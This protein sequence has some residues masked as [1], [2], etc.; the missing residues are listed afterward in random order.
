[1]SYSRMLSR[2]R[3]GLRR[4]K[5]SVLAEE[6]W[7]KEGEAQYEWPQTNSTT[8]VSTQNDRRALWFL[9]SIEDST[10]V[11]FKHDTIRPRGQETNRLGDVEHGLATKS[12]DRETDLFLTFRECR[13][14]LR[15]SGTEMVSRFLGPQQYPS[16]FQKTE[17]GNF[18]LFRRSRV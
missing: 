2:H 5:L 12:R 8:P 10:A 3:F 18:L 11:R 15:S 4:T 1:M 17:I 6:E 7:W 16:P 9:D 14:G 13:R